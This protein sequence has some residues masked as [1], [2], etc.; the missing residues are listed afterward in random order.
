M[1]IPV[2]N[3][4]QSRK[5]QVLGD[6]LAYFCG[7]H[8]YRGRPQISWCEA[9]ES[10]GCRSLDFAVKIRPLSPQLRHQDHFFRLK[11]YFQLINA[12]KD[13]ARCDYKGTL[14]SNK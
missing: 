2:I 10:I 5:E 12:G 14:H 4:V 1:I 6:G 11:I 8:I 7:S 9:P 13:I 3:K